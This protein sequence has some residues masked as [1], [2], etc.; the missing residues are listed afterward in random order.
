[1]YVFFW[2]ILPAIFS[3]AGWLLLCRS[4][5]ENRFESQDADLALSMIIPARNEEKN[6]K[7]LLGSLMPQLRAQDECIVVDDHS[8]DATATVVD[9]HGAKLLKSASLPSGWT[10]KTFALHQGAALAKQEYYVFLDADLTVE[11]GGLEK[12]R[13]CAHRHGVFSML[14][15]HRVPRWYEQLSLFFQLV[16]AAGVG[17]F[18]HRRIERS[19]GMFGQA[20]GIRRDLYL[21]IGTH[22][23]VKD[24]VLENFYLARRLRDEKIAIKNLSGRNILSMRMYPE[25]FMELYRGW[26][27]AFAQGASE[28]SALRLSLI[29]L[30]ITGCMAAVVALTM[31]TPFYWKLFIY[32]FYA[33]QV[34]VYAR[35]LGSYKPLASLLF[36]IPLFF[37][38]V[39]FFHS[40]WNK[41]TGRSASWKGRSVG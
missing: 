7:Q 29:S 9:A 11:A 37:Y 23:S 40:L 3:G 30:W 26:V 27:K 6:L 24:C 5:S 15:Y 35:A 1:M 16:M 39:V 13:Q 32:F 2:V 28:T 17:A 19:P 18:E 38:Q 34:S 20:M 21:R 10:G 41:V 14:P 25:G 33:T 22:A 8:T 4:R 31:P 12:I 36:P